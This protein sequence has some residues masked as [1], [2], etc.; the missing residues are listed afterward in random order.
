MNPTSS[1]GSPVA[2]NRWLALVVLCTAS[3]MIILDGT[4]VTV[5]LPRIQADLGFTAGSLSWVMNSFFIAFGALLL[6]SGRLGDLIGRRRM[7]LS[8]I[9]VFVLASLACGLAAGPGML[10]AARFVQGA[11][12]AMASSVT[13]GMIVRLFGRPDEQSKAIGAF[14]FTGAVG[15]S[16]GLIAGGL[17][18]QYASWH[19]IFFVNLPTG[20]AT[21]IAGW[22]VLAPDPGIGLRAGADVLGALLATSGVMLAVFAIAAP[23]DWWAGLVA[24]GLLAA[25]AVR[26]VTARTPLLPPRLLASR[27]VSGANLAQLLVIG[28]AMGFQVIVT[29]YMQRALGYR[30]AQAGLGLVPTAAVIAAVSLGL[31]ARLTA[32]FGARPLLLT[33]LVMITAALA[34]LTQLPAHAGYAA[35][36][37][38][39]LV[40]FG[41]GAGLT[42][43]A[44]TALGM[45]GATDADAGVISGVFNTAQQVGGA[46]GVALLTTLAAW[47]TGSGTSAQSLT[48]GYQLAWAAGGALGAASIAVAAVMLRPR[49]AARGTGPGSAAPCG[50]PSAAASRPAASSADIV[51]T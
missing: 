24:A 40:L 47:R 35:R 3:L 16:A 37:L 34:L 1:W 30:P 26:Q 29:L 50:E 23:A 36:L 21:W 11:G 38:P 27:G 7:F 45:A 6:L 51:C 41:L 44:V 25:F 33:G 10:I 43:P 8:G 18:V 42:L 13:L 46:L 28:A 31:S 2:R 14:A 4:I 17:L 49:R 5:A 48:S 9:A 19:W 20:L 32:R 12:A 15:A 22:R 39:P